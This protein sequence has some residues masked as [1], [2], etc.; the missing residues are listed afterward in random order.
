MWYDCC[1]V[2]VLVTVFVLFS[3]M[4]FV[5]VFVVFCFLLS[6]ISV[7][8]ADHTV[9]PHLLALLHRPDF[10]LKYYRFG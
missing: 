3:F 1:V 9:Y 4:F 5:F 6:F 2:A 7:L 8:L 10:C